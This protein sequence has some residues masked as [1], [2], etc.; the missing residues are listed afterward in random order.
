MEQKKVREIWGFPLLDLLQTGFNGL[1]LGT[2]I[3]G[4]CFVSRQ[5]E[6]ARD[7]IA[8]AGKAAEKAE[9]HTSRSLR[10]AE[11]QATA[12]HGLV[13][14]NVAAAESTRLN[15]ENSFR[16]S[17]ATVES[18]R[19]ARD[20]LRLEQRAWLGVKGHRPFAWG[21]GSRP[22]LVLLV[23]NLGRSPAQNADVLAWFEYRAGPPEARPPLARRREAGTVE[24]VDVIYP[25]QETLVQMEWK[26]FSEERMQSVRA[27]SSKLYVRLRT[28]Y[29]DIFGGSHVTLYCGV[30]SGQ[31]DQLTACDRGNSAD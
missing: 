28:S 22:Q 8:E 29:E 26:D 13:A 16:I 24:S 19:T 31:M 11:D 2:A 9:E 12:L 18:V 3:L 5:I 30:V 6:I 21:P 1:L 17:E 15:A 23:T 14:A 10:I 20:S 27:G 4:S 7:Q 25:G